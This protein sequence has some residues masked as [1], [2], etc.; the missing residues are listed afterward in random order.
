MTI[1]ELSNELLCD[2]ID[3]PA[4]EPVAFLCIDALTRC[5]YSPK[6]GRARAA[7]QP[8]ARGRATREVS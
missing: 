5:T 4:I 6:R 3:L 8:A 7:H 1:G 2:S